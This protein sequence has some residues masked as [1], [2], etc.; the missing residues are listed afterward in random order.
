VY[1]A[2]ALRKRYLEICKDEE[3]KLQ[4][5]NKAKWPEIRIEDVWVRLI[6]EGI[7]KES[8]DISGTTETN[9][10]DSP[11]IRKLCVFFRELSRDKLVVYDGVIEV[12]DKLKASGKGIYLLSNAQRAFTEKELEVAGLKD[13]FDDIFISSD[14]GIK[15]PQREFLEKLI[16]DNSLISEKCVMIGNDLLSDV[17]VAFA[18]GINSVFLNTYDY[19]DKKIDEELTELGIKGSKFMPLIVEDGDIRRILPD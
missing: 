12:M 2:K 1:T 5:K 11:E 9:L 14:K 3:K 6:K 15:K 13:Y 17:G 18:N 19:S 16:K 10:A 7:D 8:A 4:Q